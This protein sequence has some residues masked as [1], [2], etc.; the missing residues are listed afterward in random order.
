MAVRWHH[1]RMERYDAV[2][3]GAGTAG[4]STAWQLAKRGLRVAFTDARPLAFARMAPALAVYRM[5]PEQPGR[6]RLKWWSRAIATVMG[7]ES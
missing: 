4:A 5:Y 1:P 7:D 3:L 6:R 2:V